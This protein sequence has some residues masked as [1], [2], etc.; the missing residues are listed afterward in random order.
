MARKPHRRPPWENQYQ[1][2]D[3]MPSCETTKGVK[4]GKS[5]RLCFSVSKIQGKILLLER[6]C[7]YRLGEIKMRAH[8]RMCGFLLM[9]QRSGN[10]PFKGICL[11]VETGV[12][13]LDNVNVFNVFMLVV[14]V[15]IRAG[16]SELNCWLH[17]LHLSFVT[18]EVKSLFARQAPTE[19]T[20]RWL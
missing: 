17:S 19:S 14:L 16:G 18:K 3:Q 13:S 11:G 15:L 7:V 10:S 8:N 12:G 20:T 5:D 2:L 4:N 1:Q 6:P 9:R